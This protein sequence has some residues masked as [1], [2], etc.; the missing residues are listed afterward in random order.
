MLFKKKTYTDQELVSYCSK[1]DRRAQ[2]YLYKKYFSKS[3]SLMMYHV[4]D[5]EKSS[6]IVN[7][8]FLKVFKNIE[9][10]NDPQALEAWINTI[11]MRT[12]ADYFRKDSKYLRSVILEDPDDQST[13]N[14]ALSELYFNDIVKLIDKLP[15]A[16]AEVFKL[17]AIEG[18]K[19]NEIAKQLGISVGT[20]KW[21][22]SAAR[23]KL[24]SLIN[25]QYDIRDVG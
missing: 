20:S 7:H 19:H 22:L 8:G 18:Y 12:R 24:K 2:E 25:E 23:Q 5:P 4:R 17:F 6:E 14:T 3:M 16:S 21:H 15:P 10:I 1:N 9:K 11:M 13:D